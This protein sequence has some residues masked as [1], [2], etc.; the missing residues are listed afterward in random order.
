MISRSG[1]YRHIVVTIALQSCFKSWPDL[2]SWRQPASS[3][4]SSL[5][6]TAELCGLYGLECY[7]VLAKKAREEIEPR[8]GRASRALHWDE[9]IQ[10]HV[11]KSDLT[12]FPGIYYIYHLSD[13]LAT[14]IQPIPIHWISSFSDAQP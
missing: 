7:V 3:A 12:S 14:I 13:D 5:T 9:F 4:L 11:V 6:I 8:D 2:A 10:L 1:P